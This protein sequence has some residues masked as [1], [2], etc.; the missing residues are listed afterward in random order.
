M[1]IRKNQKRGF[2]SMTNIMEY[3]AEKSLAHL[4]ADCDVL[5]EIGTQYENQLKG[6]NPATDKELWLQVQEAKEQHS[7]LLYQLNELINQKRER[8]ELAIEDGQ[9]YI[10]LDNRYFLMVQADPY[11]YVLYEHERYYAIVENSGEMATVVD[12]FQDSGEKQLVFDM[13]ILYR[14]K[15]V[16]AQYW[17]W[18]KEDV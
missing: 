1:A 9:R 3:Y 10:K 16:D 6:I 15:E 5:C 2:T 18:Q 11:F 14:Y 13:S 12:F 7:E 4:Q 8:V 17:A